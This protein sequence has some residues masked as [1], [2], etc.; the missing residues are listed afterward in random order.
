[1]DLTLLSSLS[2]TAGLKLEIAADDLINMVREVVIQTTETV[3][4]KFDEERSPKFMP[5]KDAMKRLDIKSEATMINWERKGYLNPH[6]MGGRVYY[7][8][9]EVDKAFE[10]FSRQIM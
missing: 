1:M 4:A 6:R 9:D 10:R 3:L 2:N 7:R 8:Q 5:R